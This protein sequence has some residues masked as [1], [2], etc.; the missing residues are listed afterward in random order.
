MNRESIV[1]RRIVFCY[2]RISYVIA[3]ELAKKDDH[4]RHVIYY[5]CDRIVP[6][7]SETA[8]GAVPLR[9]KKLLIGVF[10]AVFFR[11]DEVLIPHFKI[12]RQINYIAHRSKKLSLL[13]DGLDT[14]RETP[15]NLT[16]SN[17][18]KGTF[19]YTFSYDV[20]LARWLSPFVLNKVCGLSELVQDR[21]PP[22]NLKGMPC[23]VIESPGITPAFV[24]DL[25]SSSTLVKHPNWNKNTLRDS[26]IASIEGEIALERSLLSFNGRLI[27]GESMVL[28]YALLMKDRSF[29]IT[30]CLDRKTLKN[31]RTLHILLDGDKDAELI[32]SSN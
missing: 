5:S 30:A 15:R 1:R 21:R 4:I 10:M 3:C 18:E 9:R 27:V 6:S 32:Q 7:P 20:S 23:L 26:G 8:L 11:P 31:L 2:N 19:Y 24:R 29:R 14:F 25:P 28:V 12:N 17:F 13:D 16:P 22:R